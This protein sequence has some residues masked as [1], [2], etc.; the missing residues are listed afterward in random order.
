MPAFFENAELVQNDVQTLITITA[1][2]KSFYAVYIDPL[3]ESV[4]RDDLTMIMS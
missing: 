3:R 4:L 1:T 2:R